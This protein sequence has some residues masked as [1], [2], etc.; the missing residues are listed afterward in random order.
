MDIK[1]LFKLSYG[2][3]IA[4]VEFEGAK[5]ACVINTAAQATAEPN[6]VIVTMMKSNRTTELIEKKGSLT[7]SVLSQK[8]PLDT[9]AVFGMRSSRDY[10][11]FA[12]VAYKE[13]ANKNPYLEETMSAF[14]GLTIEKTVDIDTHLLFICSVDE[15]ECLAEE[16][17]MTYNDYRILKSGGSLAAPQVKTE[18]RY[19]CSICHYVY[20]GDIPFEELPDD[21]VCPVC[22]QPKSVFVEE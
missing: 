10:D 22:K 6:R 17:P 5:S 20:D 8:T 19:V 3:Y 16:P 21:Y 11:K 4:G 1:A 2:L 13:D 12:E 15:A 9:I 14:L 18:K 7:I